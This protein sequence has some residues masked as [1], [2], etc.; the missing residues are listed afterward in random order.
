MT[1]DANS[2]RAEILAAVEAGAPVLGGHEH[3]LKLWRANAGDP[4]HSIF[5]PQWTG[6]T[7]EEALA[8]TGLGILG[9]L[10]DALNDELSYEISMQP[11]I[12]AVV[13]R[14]CEL[15]GGSYAPYLDAWW[16]K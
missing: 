1:A 13:R 12:Q 5:C 4:R 10:V 9:D 7:L 15:L 8:A 2:T 11:E 6:E 14:A 3:C 16:L